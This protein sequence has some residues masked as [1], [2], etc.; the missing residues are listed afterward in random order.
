MGGSVYAS[1][2]VKKLED[3]ML[4]RTRRIIRQILQRLNEKQQRSGA[5]ASIAEVIQD[6]ILA[7][8]LEKGKKDLGHI[9][10]TIPSTHACFGRSPGAWLQLNVPIESKNPEIRHTP[11]ESPTVKNRAAVHYTTYINRGAFG[12]SLGLTTRASKGC[13]R[14]VGD[15]SC[16]EKHWEGWVFDNCSIFI[17][18]TAW[19][20]DGYIITGKRIN[21]MMV[22]A[23]SMI[24]M[25]IITEV[26]G[27]MATYI[28]ID[29]SAQRST[30]VLQAVEQCPSVTRG[31]YVSANSGTGMG[32]HGR[33]AEAEITRTY[34]ID[35]GL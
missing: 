8:W 34:A 24:K 17:R 26:L 5:S 29:E 33:K 1:E 19:K 20:L 30:E 28:C 23:E 32:H 14:Q 22:K 16:W 13:D 10:R 11:L 4:I 27:F 15:L 25:R 7:R 31:G 6:L 3:V 12:F 2:R 35:I 9:F 18:E 21:V